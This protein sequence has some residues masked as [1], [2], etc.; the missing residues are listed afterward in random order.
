MRITLL[1]PAHTAIGSRVPKENLPR[2][3]LLCIGGQLIDAGHA[4]SLVNADPLN[5]SLDIA[6]SPLRL[7]LTRGSRGTKHGIE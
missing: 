1:H 4:V 5:L 6:P 3:G 7:T 2:F